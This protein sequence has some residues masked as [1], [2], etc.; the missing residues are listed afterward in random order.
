[1]IQPNYGQYFHFIPNENRLFS[2]FSRGGILARNGFKAQPD[3]IPTIY[4][5][6]I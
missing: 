2:G 3:L 6:Y 1:M 5:E 4:D